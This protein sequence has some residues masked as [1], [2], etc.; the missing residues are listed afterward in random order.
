MSSVHFENSKKI[1]SL[2]SPSGLDKCTNY[3]LKSPQS[4]PQPSILTA[5]VGIKKGNVRQTKLSTQNNK[6]SD[7]IKGAI[8]PKITYL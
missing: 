6:I 7:S 1:Y 5:H 2:L 3:F 4:K 8:L